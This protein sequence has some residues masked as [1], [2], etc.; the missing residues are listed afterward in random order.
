MLDKINVP[1]NSSV[2]ICGNLKLVNTIKNN[3]KNWNIYYDQW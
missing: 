3:Y 2:Y 1:A